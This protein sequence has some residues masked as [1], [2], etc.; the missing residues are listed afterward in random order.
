[1]S[2]QLGRPMVIDALR[3]EFVHATARAVR[4][5]RLPLRSAALAFTVVALIAATAFAAGLLPLGAPLP[6]PPRGDVPPR[7]LPRPGSARVDVLRVPDPAAGLPWGVR[8]A[9]TRDGSICYAFGR[10]QQRTLGVVDAAGRFRPLPVAGTGSCGDLSVDP[11]LFDLRRL[12]TS[13]GGER[14]LIGGV[15][16]REVSR[17]TGETAGRSR[18]LALSASGA[19]LAVYEGRVPLSRL[20]LVAHFRDGSTRLLLGGD[21]SQGRGG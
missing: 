8:V 19:F 16:G 4:P 21:A 9:R 10:V 3:A 14:T 5:P 13:R 1:M 15:A 6:G 11:V 20:R 12:E 17:I 18:T 2:E 7:L